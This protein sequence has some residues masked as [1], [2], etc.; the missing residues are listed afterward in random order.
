MFIVGW[1][2][3]VI[4]GVIVGLVFGH[5][6]VQSLFSARIAL[7]IVLNLSTRIIAFHSKEFGFNQPQTVRV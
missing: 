3:Q 4:L 7:T 1:V 6:R 2:D 5:M